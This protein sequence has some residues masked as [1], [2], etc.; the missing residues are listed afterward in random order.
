MT[1][2]GLCLV[3]E[4]D[5]D[6]SGLIAFILTKQG[7]D[8]HP[9]A[10]GADGIDAAARLGPALITLDIGLPDMDGREV[11]RQLRH[12]TTVPILMITAV[13]GAGDEFDGMVAGA[14]GYLTKPFRPA[15]LRALVERLCTSRPAAQ[16]PTFLTSEV[17]A[18]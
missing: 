15:E 16:P 7:F 14:D 9:A 8:V 5:E 12:L 1:S 18:E 6:I 4:D 10:S 2:R 13:A 11:A 17:A 3:I